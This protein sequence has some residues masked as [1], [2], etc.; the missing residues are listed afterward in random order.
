MNKMGTLN[1]VAM[2]EGNSKYE[3]ASKREGLIYQREVDIRDVF[4][5]DYTRILFS[6]GYRRLKHK[7]QVFFAVSNDH[8]CTRLEHTHLVQSISE[9]IAEY[10]GLNVHLV[11][12]I[13]AGHD[14]GHAP[15][16]H[17]GEKILSELYKNCGLDDFFH[18]KNSLYFVDKIETLKD[19]QQLEQPLN[20]TYAV[21]DGIIAHCGE[22]H[23]TAILPREEYI[24][25]NDYQHPGQFAPYTYEGCVVKMADKIAYLSRDIEDALELG[26]LTNEDLFVLKKEL[27]KIDSSIS[28]IDNGTL[29]HYFISDVCLNSSIEIG[30]GLSKQAYQV[31]KILMNY[32]YKHI[33][34]NQRLSIFD[35]YVA[36][37]IHSL[38]NILN[39]QWQ[40]KKIIESLSELAKQYPDL[41]NYFIRWLKQYAKIDGYERPETYQNSFLYDLSIRQDY[42]KA[43]L[44]YISGMTDSFILKT[45]NTL[46][47]F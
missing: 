18:E 8:V 7:T 47:S 41:V 12:A 2:F 33:Y 35:D 25:L 45:F 39:Q 27:Q 23:M 16:G 22:V 19:D 31:M 44:D 9:S 37:M 15:F 5:R 32:N 30:I 43:I 4:E 28:G 40:E 14:L 3:L 10:L 38:F 46:V 29:I 1:H 42:Q 21:R 34:L 24:D 17:G 13:A 11:R 36:L 20:L 26:F 6:K